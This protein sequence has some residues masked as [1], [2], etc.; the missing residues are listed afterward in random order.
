MIEPVTFEDG[1]VIVHADYPHEPGRLWDC[2]ACMST[3][4]CNPCAS[5]RQRLANCCAQ[6]VFCASLEEEYGNGS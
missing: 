6:C 2:P 1:T 3:C 4:L 5:C